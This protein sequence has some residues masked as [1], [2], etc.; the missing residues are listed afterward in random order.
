M[1]PPEPYPGAACPSAV[2][3]ALPEKGKKKRGNAPRTA[4]AT[5]PLLPQSR[6]EEREKENLKALH[7]PLLSCPGSKGGGGMSQI[8]PLFRSTR[9]GGKKRGGAFLY[10]SL[11]ER[12][13]GG[14]KKAADGRN[15]DDLPLPRIE[16]TG[17]GAPTL[18]RA[19]SR[20]APQVG[21]KE[22]KKKTSRENDGHH[23]SPLFSGKED[24]N[25]PSLPKR[26]SSRVEPIVG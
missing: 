24:S 15:V 13:G 7:L 16:A 23:F 12:G 25:S 14:G 4:R 18:A 21:K 6:R 17:E 1:G 9:G 11:R 3:R 22:K 20:F 26:E 19:L 5:E 10:P 2:P 8:Q